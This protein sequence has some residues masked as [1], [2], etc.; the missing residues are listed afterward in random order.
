MK[1]TKEIET[2]QQVKKA[3]AILKKYSSEMTINTSKQ[4]SETIQN[5]KVDAVKAYD[6]LT[7][8]IDQKIEHEE[9]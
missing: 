6:M 8:S 9:K 5:D 4:S 7:K 1:E 3:K 2:T